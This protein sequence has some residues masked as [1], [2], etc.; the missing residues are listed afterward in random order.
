LVDLKIGHS[1]LFTQAED[2]VILVGAGVAWI[3]MK[4]HCRLS[5]REGYSAAS[6]RAA[7]GNTFTHH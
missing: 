6:F 2:G 7:K 4:Q 3:R 1:G 5:L